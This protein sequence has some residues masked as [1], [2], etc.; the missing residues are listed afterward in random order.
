MNK[1]KSQTKVINTEIKGDSASLADL[2]TNMLRNKILDLSL[3]PSEHLEDRILLEKF[4]FGRTPL[5][6]ALNRLM[7]EGLVETKNGRG[8]YVASMSIWHTL[9]LLEAYEINERVV[10]SL[11]KFE[12][13]GLIGDLRNVQ[14]NFEKVSKN[15]DLLGITEINSKFHNRLAKSTGNKFIFD[16]SAHLHNLVRRLSYFVYRSEQVSTLEISSQ[17]PF[18]NEHHNKIIEYIEKFDRNHLMQVMNEHTNLF[19]KRLSKIIEGK[20]DF[21]LK[22]PSIESSS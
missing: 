18:I 21:E 7:S 8:A 3:A 1:Q 4:S 22:F 2:A 12:D 10:A 19:R 17:L 14:I 13:S 6:E 20:M 15:L 11:I 5:R 16:Q 9:Q